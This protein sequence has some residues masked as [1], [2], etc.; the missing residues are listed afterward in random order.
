MPFV[1]VSADAE[2]IL[3]HEFKL[4]NDRLISVLLHSWHEVTVMML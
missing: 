1:F 4:V 3:N 2:D